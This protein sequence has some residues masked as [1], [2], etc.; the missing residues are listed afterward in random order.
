LPIVE[1]VLKP[2]WIENT[3]YL[4]NVFTTRTQVHKV[5]VANLVNLCPCGKNSYWVKIGLKIE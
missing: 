2:H 4:S 1:A 5:T 3:L